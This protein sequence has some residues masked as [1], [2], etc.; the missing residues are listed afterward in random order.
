MWQVV[1]TVVN[2]VMNIF[3]ILSRIKGFFTVRDRLLAQL[4]KIERKIERIKDDKL[5]ADIERRVETCNTL[6]KDTNL[7]QRGN[8]LESL[9]TNIMKTATELHGELNRKWAIDL[10]LR[11]KEYYA[12]IDT[13]DKRVDDANRNYLQF[14]QVYYD[15]LEQ[16]R[17]EDKEYLEQ[18]QRQLMNLTSLCRRL[19]SKDGTS[20][21][22]PELL[23]AKDKR[24]ESFAGDH[25][26]CEAKST[27]AH[28]RTAV[29]SSGYSSGVATEK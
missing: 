16:R 17:R 25:R 24:S 5:I 21:E 1:S 20:A 18:L 11:E 23:E 10:N 12:K 29:P 13:L 8:D 2:T 27:M 7:A 22:A 14:Q 6:I 4:Q 28:S 15:A 26:C 3:S 9:I 19:C